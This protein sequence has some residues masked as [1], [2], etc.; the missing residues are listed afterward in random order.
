MMLITNPP[1][2]MALLITLAALYQASHSL[3]VMGEINKATV[4]SKELRDYS[5]S[6]QGGFLTI[7]AK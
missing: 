2:L 7:F 6:C 5:V 4:D 1:I 3:V